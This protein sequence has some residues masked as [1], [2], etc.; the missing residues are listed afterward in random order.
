MK[1]SRDEMKKSVTAVILAAMLVSLAACGGEKSGGETTPVGDSSETSA[2]ETANPLDDDLGEYDFGGETFTIN[3]RPMNESSWLTSVIDVDSSETGDVL[4]DAIYK[5]NRKLEQ[6]FNFVLKETNSDDR[7]SVARRQIMSG[8][9]DFDVF[10]LTN[11]YAITFAQEGLIVPIDTIKEIDLS[12]PY[13]S[14]ALNESISINGRNYFAYGDFELMS[15]DYTH[16]LIFNKKVAEDFSLESPYELVKSGKWTIDAMSSMMKAVTGDVNGDT[17]M[18]ENDRWGLLS[19]PKQVLPGFWIAA[20]VKTINK[21]SE[22][23]PVFTVPTDKH[24]ADVID[25]IFSI[26]RDSG[27]WCPNNEGLN[28]S[29]KLQEIFVADRGLFSDTTFYY[30]NLLRDMNTDFGV[31]PYPKWNEDQENYRSRVEGGD[32]A[33]IPNTA[34][35]E[36]LEMTGVILEAMASESAKSVI[37]EY[38]EKVLKGKNTRDNESEDMLDIIY[39]NR[40]FD[41]GDA[42][43]Y[44]ELRDGIF[45]P[46]FQKDDRNLSSNMAKVKDKL[47]SKLA[48]ITEAFKALD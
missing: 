48:D 17:V 42:W 15:Y 2:E 36:R 20:D 4:Y 43:Y 45:A 37:P 7:N 28:Y 16:M 41:L 3:I 18:D 32:T 25:K 46:M 5:R 10:L 35:D 13:W 31:L 19:T 21:N 33:I 27:V 30:V 39:N 40:V 26:T 24:F 23:I 44:V 29:L 22:D 12:K 14:Q 38:Y 8:S 34:T 1:N 9:P 6:R 11:M 47:D